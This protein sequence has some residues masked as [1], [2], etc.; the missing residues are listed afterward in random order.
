MGY[1]YNGG[2]GESY[3]GRKR[4]AHN[5]LMKG[6]YLLRRSEIKGKAQQKKESIV[7]GGN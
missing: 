2:K 4:G 3:K 5:L 7:Y 1:S 6:A